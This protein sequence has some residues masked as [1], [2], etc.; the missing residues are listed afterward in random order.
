MKK[1]VGTVS[2]DLSKVFDSIPHDFLI[3]KMYA[4][5]FS[6]NTVVTFFYSWL[7]GWIQNVRINN[8]HNVF[9][10]LSSGVPLGLILGP[11]L[12]NIFIND[13]YLWT[14]KTDLLNFADD[15]TITAAERTTENPI[16]TLETESQ[17]PIEWFKLNK[18]IV[19]P[20]KRH[21]IAVKKNEKDWKKN[22][23]GK[24]LIHWILTT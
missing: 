5:R 20:D 24:I 1:F 19:N 6:I 8:T 14:T 23:K 15:S 11:L 10:I 12:F 7:K 13:L 17:A 9:Q 21:A 4:Y 3:G 22:E 2:M 18:M 16:S